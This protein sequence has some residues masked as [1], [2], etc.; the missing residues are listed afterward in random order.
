M[1]TIYSQATQVLIYLGEAL[2]DSDLAM[3][4]IGSF[5]HDSMEL[6]GIRESIRLHQAVIKIFRRP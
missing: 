4:L 2:E 6:L 1:L 5:F 3:D